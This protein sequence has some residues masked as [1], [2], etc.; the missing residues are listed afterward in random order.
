MGEIQK[1]SIEEITNTLMG[2]SKKAKWIHDLSFGIC[3]EPI[4]ERGP[5]TSATAV[6]TFIKIY[7]FSQLEKFITL[8]IMDLNQKILENMEELNIFPCSFVINY[9]DVKDGWKMKS[10]RH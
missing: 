7:T 4:E 6:K 1:L 2:D 9:Q 8:C 10:Q 5:P 3:Y